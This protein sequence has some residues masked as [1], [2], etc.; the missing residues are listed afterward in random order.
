M[1][2]MI[3]LPLDGSDISLKAAFAAKSIAILL[4]IPVHVLYA[5]EEEL[6]REELLNKLKINKNDLPRN[7]IS[8][9]KGNPVDVILEEAKNSEYVVMSSH[10]QGY[11]PSKISGSVAAKVIENTN[12]PVLLIRPD[13]H[14]T[15]NGNF[16]TPKNALIPLNGTPCAS[17]ALAPAMEILTRTG[18]ELDL[19]HVTI[20]TPGR[21]IEPGAYTAPYY[22]DYSQH[23]WPSW[24]KEFLKR[25]GPDIKDNIKIEFFV[26]SGDP[27]EEII[28]Y[29]KQNKNDLIAM[30][31]HG[32]LAPPHA[33]ILRKVMFEA[34]CPVLLIK[35]CHYKK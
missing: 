3:L 25:F 20:S 16:W 4:D 7:V 29:A 10:G 22:E 28:N 23:E 35:I 32:K 2:K 12:T 30:A 21:H 13:I 27:A 33:T 31:W 6:S 11:D 1:S 5:S 14:L 26:S 24:S 15:N 9:K 17:P 18:A 34:P 19:L 8:H